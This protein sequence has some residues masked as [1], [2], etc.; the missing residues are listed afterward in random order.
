MRVSGHHIDL[1][2]LPVRSSEGL[3]IVLLF[4]LAFQEMAEGSGLK[5]R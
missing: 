1:R 3:L 5:P 2:L 4:I